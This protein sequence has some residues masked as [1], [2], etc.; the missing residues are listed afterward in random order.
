[1]RL[2]YE[3]TVKAGVRVAFAP[4][5]APVMLAL[6]AFKSEVTWRVEEGHLSGARLALLEQSVSTAE[7]IKPLPGFEE[8]AFRFAAYVANSILKQTGLDAI[9]AEAVLNRSP[10][11]DAETEEE[12]LLLVSKKQKIF[13]RCDIFIT[14]TLDVFK[15]ADNVVHSSA[16]ALYAD[17]LRA[18]DPFVR[19][20]MFYRAM[21]YF[22]PNPQN[23]AP[24]HLR[25]CPD[26]SGKEECEIRA[27]VRSWDKLRRRSVHPRPRRDAALHRDDLRALHEV[28]FQEACIQRVARW[29][30]DNPPA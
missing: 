15:I 2:V 17:G 29:L 28:R 9:D 11:L 8:T 19:F 5:P 25:N 4:D 12:R 13:A 24:R 3:L 16:L 1:L 26:F 21:E 20:E 23:A 22:F 14:G 6:G 10:R 18:T 27:Q 7:P 30:L